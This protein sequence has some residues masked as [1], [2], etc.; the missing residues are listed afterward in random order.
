M[1][2][3]ITI[4]DLINKRPDLV[5]KILKQRSEEVDLKIKDFRQRR[6]EKVKQIRSSF[7]NQFGYKNEA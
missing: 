5:L 7:N 4:K 1:L 2:D 6:E 3:K